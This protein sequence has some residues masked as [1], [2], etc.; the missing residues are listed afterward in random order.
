MC[1]ISAPIPR[2]LLFKN[3]NLRVADAQAL[4][5]PGSHTISVTS[6]PPAVFECLGAHTTAHDHTRV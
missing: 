1:C 6:T 4:L 2:K 3:V 5:L